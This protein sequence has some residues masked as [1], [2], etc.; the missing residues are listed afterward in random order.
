ML[1]VDTPLGLGT[2]MRDLASSVLPA[3][4]EV[5]N[6]GIA[7]PD[8]IGLMG[9]SYGGYS[10][11]ALLVQTPRFRAAIARGAPGDLVSYYGQMTSQGY[12]GFIGWLEYGGGRMG[13][14]PWQFR[15]EYIEN[16]PVFFLDRVQTPLLLVHGE[17][18]A[19][20][21]AAQAEEIFV[22]LRRLGKDVKYAK[23]GGE[24][25]YEGDW[26]YSNRIDYFERVMSWFDSH[27]KDG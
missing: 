16:S 1:F 22:G 5:I 20:V 8:R 26:S 11:L 10:V 9:Q 21:S 15:D 7:N 13:G 6:L 27:L 23:Y 25:H 24:G 12:P 3:L 18:D 17:A 4:N 2:P 14:T 19:T